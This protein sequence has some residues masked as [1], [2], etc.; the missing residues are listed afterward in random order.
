MGTLAAV[1]ANPIRAASQRLLTLGVTLVVLAFAA[2]AIAAEEEPPPPEPVP[3]E[4]IE[5]PFE[6][7]TWTEG[8][9]DVRSLD[10]SR[11][12]LIGHGFAG[13]GLQVNIPTGGFRGLGPFDRLGVFDDSTT[14]PDQAWF[15][16]HLRLLDWDAAF[17]GKLPGLAGIYSSSARGCIQPTAASPGWSAR[18]M[19]GVPGTNGAGP[20]QVPI[21]T[22]LYHADQ[23]GDCGDGLWWNTGLEQGR[24]HCIEG[25]VRMN[26]PGLNDGAI[27]GWLDGQLQLSRDDIQY[28]RPGEDDLGVRHMWHNVYFGGSWSTPNPLSLVYDEVVVSTTGRVGCMKPFTDLGGTIHGEAITQMHA[29]GYLYGCGYRLACPRREL[30]RGEAAALISR[31]LRLPPSS[32]DH[33]SDDTGSTYEEAINRLADARITLGCAPGVYC[34]TRTMTRAEFVTMLAR[35]MNLKGDVPDAFDDDTGHFAEPSINQFAA[36]GLTSGCGG[37]RFCPDRVLTRDE[38]LAFFYRS[39]DLLA[40][41]KLTSLGVPED[42]PPE[43][44]PPQI[45]AEEQD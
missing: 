28:L 39:L 12:D 5:R 14:A 19:F 13:G 38:S 24:W 36:A 6:D 45:P 20:G 17:T 37:N 41:P 8:L 26:T 40:P 29:L 10:I 34:P 7:E 2:P 4:H 35:A 31:I 18:G 33:F 22:Y 42:F 9:V 21:G 27:R 44:D 43:G 11:T 25:M 32:T 1:S 23:E 16:Y 15:R 30:N 3:I